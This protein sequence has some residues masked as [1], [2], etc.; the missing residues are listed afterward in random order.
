M[1]E[2]DPNQTSQ[3]LLDHLV[4]VDEYRRRDSDVE[5]SIRRHL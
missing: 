3:V 5:H 1:S 4:G 2:N